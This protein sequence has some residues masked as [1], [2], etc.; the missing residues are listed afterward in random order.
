M[1]PRRLLPWGK[2]PHA[3]IPWELIAC[4]NLHPCVYEERGG[5]DRTPAETR[6]RACLRAVRFDEHTRSER[7]VQLEDTD[8][9]VYVHK[10]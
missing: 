8:W 9:L 5:N 4:R 1:L 10:L 7:L 3:V 6:L 2:T